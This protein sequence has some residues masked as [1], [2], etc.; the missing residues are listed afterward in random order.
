MARTLDDILASRSELDRGKLDATTEDDLRRQMTEDGFD[1]DAEPGE[2]VLVV[3][4]KL[5]R[6]RLGL[7][8]DAFAAALRVPL[9]V[10]GAWDSGHVRP[11]A[12]AQALLRALWRDPTTVLRAARAA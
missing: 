6:E 11:D 5:V 8:P 3:P 1:P 12:A 2:A 7:T 4:P 9:D 10:V